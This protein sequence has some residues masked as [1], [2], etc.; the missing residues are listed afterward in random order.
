MF[1]WKIFQLENL[2]ARCAHI[3]SPFVADA[4]TAEEE[5]EEMQYFIH[6]QAQWPNALSHLQGLS[7]PRTSPVVPV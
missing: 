5:Q 4:I 2:S 7:I 6:S 1:L 3:I